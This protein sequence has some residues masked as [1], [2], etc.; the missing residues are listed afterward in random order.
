MG[1]LC[2]TGNPFR[3]FDRHRAPEKLYRPFRMR[4]Q[5]GDSQINRTLELLEAV[6][7]TA[8][9]TCAI[10]CTDPLPNRPALHDKLRLSPTA[11]SIPDLARASGSFTNSSSMRLRNFPQT[12]DAHIFLLF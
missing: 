9:N 2:S 12:V 1:R 4:S 8:S 10:P 3:N 6:P 5:M 11:V 7:S